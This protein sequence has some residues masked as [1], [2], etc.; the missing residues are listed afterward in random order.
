M[1]TTT[2]KVPVEESKEK[3]QKPTAAT[4]PPWGA[5]PLADS[6]H[7]LRGEIDR[8]FEH[9]FHG[10][11]TLFSPAHSL[12]AWDPFRET[13]APF[14]IMNG[15]LT[16]RTDVSETDEAYAIT[17]ELPGVDECDLDVTVAEDTITITGEKK[18]EREEKE[19]G[20]YLSERSYGSFRR[21]F[22]LPDDVDA[23]RIGAGFAN[24][25]LTVTMPR[26]PEARKK[27]RNIEIESK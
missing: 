14:A 26:S 12:W 20:R 5:G 9:A 7:S 4:S 15:G 24:G 8:A 16:P 27:V 2:R 19:K 1:T 13:R 22:R 21:S 6:L 17:I 25:V 23:G 11:P 18:S 3:A 10:W